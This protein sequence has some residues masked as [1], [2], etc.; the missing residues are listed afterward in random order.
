MVQIARSKLL[1]RW[2][3]ATHG[4][5]WEV[6]EEGSKITTNIALPVKCEAIKE[7]ELIIRQVVGPE[8]A[9]KIEVHR[10]IRGIAISVK[11]DPVAVWE[12]NKD[13]LIRFMRGG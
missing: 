1:E 4:K 8:E 2:L 12:R 13:K 9:M 7:I 3:I 11:F 10:V 6:S 5:T